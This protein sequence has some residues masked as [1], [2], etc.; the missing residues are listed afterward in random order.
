[1][2][3]RPDTLHPFLQRLKRGPLLGDGAMGTQIH[4]RGVPFERCFDELN[5]SQPKIIEEIHRA[6]I[7]AGAEVIETNSFGGNCI[8]LAR[9]GLES[10]VRDINF[11]AVKIAREARDVSGEPVFLAGSV[12][13]IGQ[14]LEPVGNVS[15]RQAEDAFKEQIEALLEGGAD[16]IIL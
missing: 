10:K 14:Q 4:A 9:H 5:L 16:L 2:S 8:K 1:M 15:L 6:Y 11:R 7:A 13:P 12:G 3:S